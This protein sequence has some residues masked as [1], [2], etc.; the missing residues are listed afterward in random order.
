MGKPLKSILHGHPN[1]PIYSGAM[2]P[3][4]QQLAPSLTYLVGDSVTR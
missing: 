4:G 2:A 1:I 3:L